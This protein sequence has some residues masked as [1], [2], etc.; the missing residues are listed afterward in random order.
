MNRRSNFT[1]HRTRSN[2]PS[3]QTILQFF[4]IEETTDC[5]IIRTGTF[6]RIVPLSILWIIVQE[7]H[8]RLIKWNFNAHRSNTFFSWK[9]CGTFLRRER[10]ARCHAKIVRDLDLVTVRLSAMKHGLSSSMR[11]LRAGCIAGDARERWLERGVFLPR[12]IISRCYPIVLRLDSSICQTLILDR[13]ENWWKLVQ[14]LLKIFFDQSFI[15][16]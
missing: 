5:K 14:R 11:L 15:Y 7:M 2:F 9:T 10:Y 8:R 6:E 16:V 3:L 4:Y 1:F 12:E 13:I